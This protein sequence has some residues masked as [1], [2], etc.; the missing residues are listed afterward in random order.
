MIELLKKMAGVAGMSDQVIATDF[1]I[2][3]KAE[4]RNYGVAITETA[5][6][7]LRAVLRNHLRDA[8]NTHEVIAN[9]M[10]AKGFYYPHDLSAQ[11]SADLKASDTAQNLAQK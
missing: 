8:I 10:I 9:Y 1:L 4:V 3:A 6:P 5:T 2:S 7:E 11:L